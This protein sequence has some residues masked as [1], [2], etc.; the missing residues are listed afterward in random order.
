[1]CYSFISAAVT[2]FFFH[3]YLSLVITFAVAFFIEIS[4]SFINFFI[5]VT[6]LFKIKKEYVLLVCCMF[7]ALFNGL[8]YYMYWVYCWSA[9]SKH[10][11]FSSSFPLVL[12][13]SLL[14]H[15]VLVFF[16]LYSV[17]TSMNMYSLIYSCF[18]LCF[19][20]NFHLPCLFLLLWIFVSSLN[21]YF[22]CLYWIRF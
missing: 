8:C 6:S 17:S 3:F 7:V 19:H 15:Q 18:H 9:L 20:L 5:T 22:F 16:W 21:A 14:F 1:M 11:H 4:T 13:N 10:S 12:I 2:I